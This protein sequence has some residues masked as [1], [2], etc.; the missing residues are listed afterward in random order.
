[1]A[2]EITTVGE[3]VYALAGYPPEHPRTAGP[4]P[5]MQ[6][7]DRHRVWDLG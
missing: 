4:R 7:P 1:M 3:L 5:R 2:A 6:R